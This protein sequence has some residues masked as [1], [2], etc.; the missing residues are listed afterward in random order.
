MTKVWLKKWRLQLN[1]AKSIVVLFGGKY[2]THIRSIKIDDVLTPWSNTV[3]YLGVTIGW[4]LN[5]GAHILVVIKKP[6][7]FKIFYNH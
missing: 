4:K 7:R 2:T 3:K 5:F 1:V 6:L